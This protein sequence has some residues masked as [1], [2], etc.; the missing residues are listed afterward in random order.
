[1]F[2]LLCGQ[3]SEQANTEHRNP[4]GKHT[5]YIFFHI[6]TSESMENTGNRMIY[7]YICMY[8]QVIYLVIDTNVPK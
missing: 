5:S 7:I 4:A 6:F 1:M 2:F 3:K 8:V